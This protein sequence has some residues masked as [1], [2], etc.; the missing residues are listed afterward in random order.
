MTNKLVQSINYGTLNFAIFESE[1]N[2]KPIKNYS[3]SKKEFNKETNTL[4]NVGNIGVNKFQDLSV[5]KFLLKNC[6]AKDRTV[7][8]YATFKNEKSIHLVKFYVDKENNDKQQVIEL[9]PSE[10]LAMLDLIERVLAINIK[11]VSLKEKQ[12][13]IDEQAIANSDIPYD[14]LV[15]D[16]IPF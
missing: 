16:D 8:P 12:Q 6:L 2:G 13:N 15:D 4:I 11:P 1:Y 7:N 3:L 10:V 14:Q 9:L 5:I